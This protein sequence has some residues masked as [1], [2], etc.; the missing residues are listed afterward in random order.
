MST[1]IEEHKFIQTSLIEI[2]SLVR[3]AQVDIS[4]FD[5]P[6]LKEIME[7]MKTPLAR[8]LLAHNVNII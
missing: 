3:A 7:N 4:K 6:K 5:A 1:E 2:L 8:S